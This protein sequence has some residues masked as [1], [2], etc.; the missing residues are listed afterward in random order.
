MIA[1]LILSVPKKTRGGRRS[2]YL[3]KRA[4]KILSERCCAAALR[5]DRL[6]LEI[7]RSREG[8]G[9]EGRL[10]VEELAAGWAGNCA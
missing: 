10:V 1:T 3:I 7:V 5:L 6:A 9:R 4:R 8:K 2:L